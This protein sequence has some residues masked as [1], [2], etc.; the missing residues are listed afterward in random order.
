VPSALE[1]P[2]NA[3]AGTAP[4]W[5]MVTLEQ[6]PERRREALLWRYAL[7]LDYLDV[8]IEVR[9][10]SLGPCP[11]QPPTEARERVAALGDDGRYHLLVDDDLLCGRRRAATRQARRSPEGIRH[12]QWCSW[13]ASATDRE[14]PASTRAAGSPRRV[15]WTVTLTPHRTDPALVPRRQRCPIWAASPHW[16][17]PPAATRL[18]RIRSRLIE[19]FG[20]ACQACGRNPGTVVDHDP[21][22][23]YVRGILCAPCNKPA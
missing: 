4:T 17:P 21:F 19:A 23:T 20:P 8:D 7:D 14:A 15:T 16:P 11:W 3:V 12:Q 6:L 9:K 5:P 18:G 22:S 2:M 10:R 13:R 1:W